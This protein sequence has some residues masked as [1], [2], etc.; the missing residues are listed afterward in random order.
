MMS[1]FE[2]YDFLQHFIYCGRWEKVLEALFLKVLSK[3]GVTVEEH[4]VCLIHYGKF[5]K[6]NSSYHKVTSLLLE[7]KEEQREGI[8][9]GKNPYCILEVLDIFQKIIPNYFPFSIKKTQGGKPLSE[10]CLCFCIEYRVNQQRAALLLPCKFFQR[11]NCHFEK[12]SLPSFSH[13]DLSFAKIKARH[14]D[15]K[16]VEL[17]LTVALPLQEGISQ[18]QKGN[19]LTTTHRIDH[20]VPIHIQGKKVG[21]G[22]IGQKENIRS[23]V[24]V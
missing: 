7:G 2:P 17:F 6:N 4:S 1:H 14:F 22:E 13:A 21:V 16:K 10:G 20:S 11:W 24:I 5:L 3:S 9:I 8:V 15:W 23:I 19:L 18:V 12:F